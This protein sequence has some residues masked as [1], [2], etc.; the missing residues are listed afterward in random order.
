MVIMTLVFTL[1]VF[2][3]LALKMYAE[4]ISQALKYTA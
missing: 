4:K 3:P 2:V 1:L